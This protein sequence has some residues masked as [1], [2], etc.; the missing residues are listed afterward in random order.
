MRTARAWRRRVARGELLDDF[1]AGI[2][3]DALEHPISRA[4]W[5]GSVAPLVS[6]ISAR[7]GRIASA[8]SFSRAWNCVARFGLFNPS[9][10]SATEVYTVPASQVASVG[11]P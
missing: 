10:A 7:N 5:F 6:S 1:L 3:A 8:R 4:A 2:A 11:C 9:I